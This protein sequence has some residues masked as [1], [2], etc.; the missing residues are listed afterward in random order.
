MLERL[1]RAPTFESAKLHKELVVEQAQGHQ[2][3]P[4][5]NWTLLSPF[6]SD[7]A[8]SQL[9][10]SNDPLESPGKDIVKMQVSQQLVPGNWEKAAP[11]EYPG[12]ETSH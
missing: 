3:V 8:L 9:A 2:H 10:E 12:L 11:T 7:S 1:L 5:Q 4:S 6:L